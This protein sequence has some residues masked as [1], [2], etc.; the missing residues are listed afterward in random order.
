M[1]AASQYMQQGKEAATR[2]ISPLSSLPLTHPIQSCLTQGR[3]HVDKLKPTVGTMAL[4]KG[5]DTPMAIM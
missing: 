5:A 3:L 1:R 4:R 2:I